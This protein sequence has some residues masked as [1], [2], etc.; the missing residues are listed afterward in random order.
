MTDM[1]T[2]IKFE[3]KEEI[4]PIRYDLVGLNKNP[5]HSD[6]SPPDSPKVFAEYREVWK[7]IMTKISLVRTRGYNQNLIL[8]A[9]YG[10]GKSHIIRFLRSQINS[11]TNGIAF[12]ANTPQS[13]K[14][15]DLY[16]SL[17]TS[18]DKN[19]LMQRIRP[20]K[21]T[22]LCGQLGKDIESALKSLFKTEKSELAWRW[23]QGLSTYSYERL[24]I[25]VKSKLERGDEICLSAL[26]GIFDAI[27]KSGNVLIFL[28]IDEVET[29]KTRTP[30]ESRNTEK[31]LEL[32]RRF[33]DEAHSNVFFLLAATEEWQKIW[34]QFGPLVSR[35]PSYDIETLNPISKI[36]EYRLFILEYLESERKDDA[37]WSKG[38]E[39]YQ[40]KK[41]CMT[42]E[43]LKESG[44]SYEEINELFERRKS[45]IEHLLF[46]FADDG[47]DKLFKITGGL[48]RNI[49]KS[50]HL[51]IEKS[52]ERASDF[53]GIEV[54]DE[55]FV[56]EHES[57]IKP[58]IW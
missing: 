2:K 40:D 6:P 56:L 36:S 39:I 52:V 55:E 14:F 22:S 9:N 1:P 12:I 8:F 11:S 41:G 4:K 21:L 34:N 32:F 38:L 50:C 16:K 53:K 29:A 54:I 28:G 51:L 45:S 18:I 15:S 31:L 49:V 30:S 19:L 7:K 5:F 3:E 23:L 35:F 17:I 42:K 25:S 48:P 43:Q 33:I 46:P 10:R 24:E 47:I 58:L 27:K 44:V 37:T 13:L 26:L 20:E 57:E